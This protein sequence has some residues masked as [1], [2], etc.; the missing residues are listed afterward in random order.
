VSHEEP[1]LISSNANVLQNSARESLCNK[2]DHWN[3]LMSSIINVEKDFFNPTLEKVPSRDG[4]D[5]PF[6]ERTT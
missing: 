1:G 3:N 6:D 4:K 2:D 5:S